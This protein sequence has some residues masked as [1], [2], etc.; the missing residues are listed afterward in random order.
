MYRD[1]I[2]KKDRMV[3]KN[4]WNKIVKYLKTANSFR[5]IF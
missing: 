3:R 2:T 1:Q 5:L 4:T